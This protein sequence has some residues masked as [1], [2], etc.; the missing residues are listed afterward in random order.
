MKRSEMIQLMMQELERWQDEDSKFGG[1]FKSCLKSIL[2]IQE[3]SGMLPPI[4]DL[5]NDE[6]LLQN[7][8]SER[9]ERAWD[10]CLARW[11]EE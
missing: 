3:E 5:C 1:G 2:K 7:D 6:T 10:D 9:F 11:E 4:L 8:A